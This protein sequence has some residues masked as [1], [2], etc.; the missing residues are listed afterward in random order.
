M[1]QQQAMFQVPQDEE[2]M[3]NHD[4]PLTEDEEK[5]LNLLLLVTDVLKT[6]TVDDGDVLIR[7]VYVPQAAVYQ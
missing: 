7:V 5:I 1:G 2:K 3:S 6:D 4:L